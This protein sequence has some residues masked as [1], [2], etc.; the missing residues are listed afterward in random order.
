[1]LDPPVLAVGA[2]LEHL[3]L[4]FERRDQAAVLN[5]VAEPRLPQQGDLRQVRMGIEDELQVGEIDVTGQ[6]EVVFPE[7]RRVGTGIA[8]DGPHDPHR[9]PVPGRLRG[10][11]GD[12][13]VRELVGEPRPVAGVTGIIDDDHVPC[14]G[15]VLVDAGDGAG[16]AVLA[17]VREDDDRDAH[18]A[19]PSPGSMNDASSRISFRM[20]AWA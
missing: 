8:G 17:A 15:Q 1:M 11:G 10:D 5:L 18:S 7:S 14:A 19:S 13:R 6:H 16:D 20:P 3:A 2:F 12:E 9:S 4:G